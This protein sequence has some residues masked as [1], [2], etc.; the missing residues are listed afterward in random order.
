MVRAVEAVVAAAW[1]LLVGVE[2]AAVVVTAELLLVVMAAVAEVVVR[3]V[4]AVA[5]TVVVE[6]PEDMSLEAD[7][8]VPEVATLVAVGA[9]GMDG[10][11]GMLVITEHP[12][13]L[14]M[15]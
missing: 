6:P 13:G 10:S 8:A 12:A 3:A 9:P 1:R 15:V 4:A 5:A 11:H 2:I 7:M 14:K